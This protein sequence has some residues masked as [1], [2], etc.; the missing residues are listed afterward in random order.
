MIEPPWS[1]SE[2][3]H[4]SLYPVPLPGRQA[5]LPRL[6]RA[7]FPPRALR[8]L[9]RVSWLIYFWIS[10]QSCIHRPSYQVHDLISK[11]HFKWLSGTSPHHNPSDP[12]PKCS[13]YAVFFPLCFLNRGKGRKQPF[14][15]LFA[16]VVGNCL[17]SLP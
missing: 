16:P 6:K 13:L 11:A 8:L 7:P 9:S 17:L 15:Y 4:S 14:A 10:L 2:G 3:A 5:H 1:R 12:F